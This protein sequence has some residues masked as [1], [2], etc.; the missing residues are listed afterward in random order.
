MACASLVPS[1]LSALTCEVGFVLRSTCVPEFYVLLLFL[2]VMLAAMLLVRLLVR[3]L[4]IHVGFALFIVAYYA[5]MIAL[6]AHDLQTLRSV[7]E[8]TGLVEWTSAIVLLV[9]GIL[10][11]EIVIR[12]R[13]RGMGA[14]LAAVLAFGGL[15]MFAREI[16]WGEPF[17]G[18]KAWYSRCFWR[19][20]AYFDSDYFQRFAEHFGPHEQGLHPYLVHMLFSCTLIVLFAALVVYLI[21]YRKE[22]GRELGGFFRKSYCWYL[23]IGVGGMALALAA[24]AVAKRIL[25]SDSLRHLREDHAI[26]NSIIEEPMELAAAACLL[27]AAVALY[28][29]QLPRPTVAPL[30]DPRD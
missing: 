8:E 18:G 21:R 15:L 17:F 9:T 3:D 23:L 22:L 28:R 7:S 27:M 6:G 1:S 2:V 30:G 5:G 16:E 25:K 12:R 4:V 13:R 29:F 11:M 24:G 20:H 26:G 10:A 19:P 14:P